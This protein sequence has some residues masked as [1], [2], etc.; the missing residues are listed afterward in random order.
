MSRE[1]ATEFIFA[2]A[3]VAVS[4]LNNH[5]YPTPGLRLGLHAF[6]A[7]AANIH[8]FPCFKHMLELGKGLVGNR[9]GLPQYSKKLRSLKQ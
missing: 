6:A 9:I 1:T 8:L 5:I 3:P 2:S 7:L 4:R